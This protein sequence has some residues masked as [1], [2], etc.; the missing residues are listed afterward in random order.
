MAEYML[1]I[2][3][4]E[5]RSATAD[6][7]TNDAILRAHEAFIARNGAAIRGGNRL[8]PSRVSTSVRHD[9]GGNVT[10]SDGAFAEAKEVIGGYYLVDVPDLD[11]ALK[12]AQEVPAPF[13]GIEVRPVWSQG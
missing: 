8:H 4:D 5:A 9:G 10:V 13:G 6:Q 3:E 7:Q 2:Y 1:L 11:A 12:V